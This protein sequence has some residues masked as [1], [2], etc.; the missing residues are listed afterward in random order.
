MT[1][2]AT[3]IALQPADDAELVEHLKS[4]ISLQPPAPTQELLQSIRLG[5]RDVAASIARNVQGLS[6]A[7]VEQALEMGKQLWRM[8]QELKR[9]EYSTF[10]SV[11]GWASAKAR[12]Y[13]NLAKTFSEFEP[14]AL[15]G[16][17]LT[18][19]LSLC[20]KRYA[21]VVEQLRDVQDITQQLVE[22]LIKE[23]RAP[24]Q[25]KSDQSFGWKLNRSGGRR[26]EVI[27]HDEQTGVSIEQQAQAEQ[28]LP[29]RV[30]AE[31]V[32]LRAQQK[33]ASMQ[34]NEYY[35]AQLDE[36][37]EV[38]NKARELDQENRHLELELSKRD[39]LIAERDRRIAELEAKL[40]S[41]VVPLLVE[42]DGEPTPEATVASKELNQPEQLSPT[43]ALATAT[44]A[45]APD[46]ITE[47]EPT[48]CGANDEKEPEQP[49]DDSEPEPTSEYLEPELPGDRLV[50]KVQDLKAVVEPN[51]T[52]G[53]GVEFAHSTGSI[54]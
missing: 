34:P 17:E 14:S 40:A 35:R 10:L 3:C 6:Q 27:L 5:W 38:V 26:Y 29:Q 49:A 8:Q 37:H 33:D 50:K 42:T 1:Q 32:A 22:Q 48:S 30:I 7:T 20:S 36:L 25:V 24:R 47:S 15:V 4:P 19:L 53:S 21:A 46:N 51:I 41:G 9:K 43:I 18:T 52:G 54:P 39:R 28:V 45:I 2:P 23:T 11:L 31:A 13:I 44:P 12:K 16:I